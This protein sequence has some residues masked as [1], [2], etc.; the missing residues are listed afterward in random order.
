[1]LVAL[2]EDDIKTVE[3]FAG[4]VSDDLLGWTESVEGERKRMAGS[5][6]NFELSAVDADALIMQARLLAGWVTQEDLD[7]MAAADEEA[8]EEEVEYVEGEEVEAVEEAVEAPEATQAP[9][10]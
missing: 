9:E 10:A 6:E 2:G 1:M 8:L 5:L 7:E 4:C 3:D